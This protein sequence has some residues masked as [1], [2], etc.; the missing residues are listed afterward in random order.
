MP[1]AMINAAG[2]FSSN[3]KQ[4]YSISKQQNLKIQEMVE[5]DLQ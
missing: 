3:K 2:W 1:M 4:H 5:Y